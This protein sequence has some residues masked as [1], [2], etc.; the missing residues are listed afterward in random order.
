MAQPSRHNSKREI[1]Q[2]SMDSFE[3]DDG[4]F[5]SQ[6]TKSDERAH[7]SGD[8][9]TESFVTTPPRND[10]YR[11]HSSTFDPEDLLPQQQP[12]QYI[13]PAQFVDQRRTRQQSSRYAAATVSEN[14]EECC[15]P[16]GRRSIIIGIIVGVFA[17]LFVLVLLAVLN[18][19]SRNIVDTRQVNAE[20]PPPMPPIKIQPP[21]PP[22]HPQIPQKQCFEPGR[23]AMLD[24]IVDTDL[25]RSFQECRVIGGHN[26]EAAAVTVKKMD[27]GWRP[28]Q[29][30]ADCYEP[31]LH[32][33][34][35]DEAT[36]ECTFSGSLADSGLALL[37][38]PRTKCN[39]FEC[40][41]EESTAGHWT[42][43]APDRVT[44]DVR[45]AVAFAC[46]TDAASDRVNP[47]LV[48][49][50]LYEATNNRTTAALVERFVPA[51]FPHTCY[52]SLKRY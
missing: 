23:R 35:M 33:S 50:V 28:L 12:Q 39:G 32:A 24:L 51:A 1:Q 3:C 26:F 19:A 13:P 36:L 40:A 11:T 30:I 2:R 29:Q 15:G 52:L 9:H 8:E 47:L 31:P 42:L 46:A 27:G 43:L 34:E 25:A 22:R 17:L 49:S 37:P 45:L 5:T 6:K 10:K 20:A 48:I 4:P 44:Q 7:E 38:V 41:C 14:R 18:N 21:Q 16:C